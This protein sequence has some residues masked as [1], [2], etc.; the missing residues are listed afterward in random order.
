MTRANRISYLLFIAVFV[1]IAMLH[2]ATPLITGLLAYFALNVLSFGNRKWLGVTLFIL[3]LGGV[4]YG[5]YFFLKHAYVTLP[6]IA[7]TTIPVVIEFTERQGVELP[8]TDY[9]SLKKLALDAVAEKIAGL[10]KYARTAAIETVAT[11]V[12][13]VVAISLFL[14][15]KLD[16]GEV[17]SADA[18]NLYS[19]LGHELAGRFRN[20]YSSFATVMGAQ[21]L[22]SAINTTLTSVFLATNHY[23]FMGVIIVLTFLCGMLP[24][25]GNLISNALIIGVGLT[26]SPRTALFALIYLVVIHKMEYFLNSKIIGDRTRNPMWLTLLGLVIG[27]KLMGIPGMILAP[28]VLHFVKLEA[29]SRRITALGE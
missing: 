5:F 26:I 13:T 24:I 3:V 18:D 25:I 19:V 4:S 16:L 20:F 28:V 14:S 27:E 8:F 22:I 10:G 29:S 12:G 23:P 2:M 17:P 9:A 7:H 1:L 6:Q 11:I 15:T 21:I